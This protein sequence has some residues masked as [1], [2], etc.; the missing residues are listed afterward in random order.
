MR[1]GPARYGN[2]QKLLYEK[3]SSTQTYF[4]TNKINEIIK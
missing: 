2:V 1:E 4:Y 3:Y